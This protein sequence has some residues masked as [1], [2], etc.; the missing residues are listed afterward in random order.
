MAMGSIIQ[1]EVRSK[2]IIELSVK[3]SANRL[4]QIKIL[5][6]IKKKI[7]NVT[8]KGVPSFRKI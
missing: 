4:L 8:A 1:C 3:I 5:G 7:L 2:N 6:F